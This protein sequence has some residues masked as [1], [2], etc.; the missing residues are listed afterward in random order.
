MKVS[1]IEDKDIQAQ[2]IAGRKALKKK[3]RQDDRRAVLER[4][5]A[6]FIGEFRLD[7]LF[8]YFLIFLLA[9]L[10]WETLLR[11]EVTGYVNRSSATLAAFVPAEALFFTSLCGFHTKRP[12]INCI[13]VT[14]LMFLLGFYYFAQFIYYR[15]FHSFISVG[16]IG[17]GGDAMDQFGWTLKETLQHSVLNGVLIFLPVVATGILSF[18]RPKH[19]KRG[20]ESLLPGGPYRFWLHFLC[21]V[22]SVGFWFLGVFGLSLLGKGRQ[23]A[24]YVMKNS[25][26]D[27]DTTAGRIGALAT[28]VVEAGTV[29]LGVNETDVSS[30]LAAV[31]MDALNLPTG[32]S[33][34]PETTDPQSTA[35]VSADIVEEKGYHYEGPQYDRVDESI[36]FNALKEKTGDS[37]TQAL[38]DYFAAKKPYSTN[39]YTG[40]FEGYNLIYI[41]AESFSNFALDEKITPTLYKMAHNGIVLN[42]FYNSFPNTTTN[43]EFAFTTSLWPDVSRWAQAGTAVGS[44]PQ[45][46]NV[47][48]PYGL[49][50]LLNSEDVPCYAAHNFYGYYYKRQ[51]SWPNL[52]YDYNNIKFLGKGMQFTSTWP[53]SDLEMFEQTV[54]DYIEDDEFHTYYMTFSGHGPYNNSNYMYNKN[55]AA[56][57]ELAGGRYTDDCCLGYFAGNYELELGVEYLVDRLEEAGKLDKTVFVII[58]DHFPYYL[59]EP[60]KKEFNGGNV[61][62]DFEEYHSTCIIYNS[63]LE[64][65]IECDT[66]CCNVDILPTMLNLFNVDFDSRLLAGTD[67]FSNGVHRARLY[68]GSFLTEYVTYDNTNGLSSY[69]RE[70]AD[71]PDDVLNRYVTA[72]IDYTESEYSASLNMMSS[73]FYFFVWRNSGLLTDEE[74]LAE[75]QREKQGAQKYQ[76]EAA[77]EAQRAAE[78]AA[79][80]ALEEQLMLQQLIEQGLVDEQGNPIPQPQPQVPD[81][82][83]QPQPQVPD[84]N[85]QQPADPNQQ[86]P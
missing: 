67:I 57:K 8:M 50:D 17:L 68:N 19:E 34:A 80:K 21:L 15:L 12:R 7:M 4:V 56:V 53:A 2:I 25:L 52:G 76:D 13:V 58:G 46:A 61:F 20:E 33:A 77:A 29:I 35:T 43:G 54:D 60:A 63:G 65:P 55:I 14:L 59:T 39:R 82:N 64:E 22:L 48:M 45:S 79:R 1:E 24:Y 32:P 51:Y 73:N 69:T 36:D 6:L 83:Q 27:T 85:Q 86:T 44:F 16:L 71:M 66:Y 49:A 3:F 18:I 9:I 38:C 10:Y 41:C 40:L 72:M 47:F 28:S 26:A 31:D 5:H 84:P 37:T 70:A 62:T 74:I 42:N 11:V 23:S 75:E 30:S 81:P 78:E